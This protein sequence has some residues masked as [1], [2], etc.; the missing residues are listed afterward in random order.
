MAH[1][2]IGQAFNS[3]TFPIVFFPTQIT[4]RSAPTQSLRNCDWSPGQPAALLSS[5]TL[6]T[7]A[8]SWT[9]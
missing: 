6:D 2:R 3:R 4:I 7:T 9:D 1:G 5:L 8:A